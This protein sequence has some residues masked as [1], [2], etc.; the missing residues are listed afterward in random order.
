[1][2]PSTVEI[3]EEP[4]IVP[5]IGRKFVLKEAMKVAV[6]SPVNLRRWWPIWNGIMG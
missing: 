4:E 2:F 6:G 5:Q 1:L 3:L